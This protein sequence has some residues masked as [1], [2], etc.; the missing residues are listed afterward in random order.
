MRSVNGCHSLEIF[1]R[2]SFKIVSSERTGL[3][4]FKQL[5]KATLKLMLNSSFLMKVSEL[6]LR[7]VIDRLK[8]TKG[9]CTFQ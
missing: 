9:T 4:M 6:D 1:I 8:F 2:L 3:P 5:L 7:R